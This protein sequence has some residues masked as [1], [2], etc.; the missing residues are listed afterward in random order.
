MLVSRDWLSD[1][2]RLDAP[3]EAL[4]ERLLMAGLNLEAIHA[5][6]NDTVIELEVTSNRPDCLGHVGVARELAVLLGLP[7]HLPD[8]RP[9]E[10]GPP[11]DVAVTIEDADICPC[12]TARVIR[13]VRVGPSPKW[14]IERLQAIGV[15]PVNNLVDVTNYVL[16]ECGQP[17]HAFDLARIR[18]RR[19]IVRRAR[20][21]ESFTALNHR[22]YHLTPAMGVIA[23]ADG[24]VALAGVMG[25]L[26]TEI[27]ADTV[28]VLLESAQFAPLVV[29]AAARGLALASPSSYRFERGPDPAA[30]DWA[31]RRACQ[32]IVE[33]AGGTLA[34]SPVAAG[35]LQAPQATVPLR[36][37]RV[38]EVL[39]MDVDDQRQRNILGGLGFVEA[40]AGGTDSRWLA[41]T[42]RRDCTREID[43]VEEIGRIEGYAHVPDEVPLSARRVEVGPRERIGRVA[44]DLLV[45][46]GFCEALTRS[47]VPIEAETTESPW[48]ARPALSIAPPL[49][50][51]AD[52]L[53]RS[54]LPSLLE[55]RSGNA[56]VGAGRADL[57][58]V[59][60]AY[61]PTAAETAVDGP[62]KEPFLVSLVTGGDFPLAKGIVE[63]LLTR[64]RIG[65]EAWSEGAERVEWRPVDLDLF[66][67][68]RAAEVVLHREGRQP[69]RIAVVGEIAVGQLAQR[70][71]EAPVA[72]AEVRLDCLEFAIGR[73]V[74]LRAA[75]DSPA[76]HRDINL[77]LD[78]AV[79]WGAVAAVIGE[80]GGPLLERFHLVQV[81][82]DAERLGTGRKSLVVALALRPRSG[83]L[84][85]EEANT[86]VAGIVTACAGRLGAELRR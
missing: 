69:E 53:R 11:A 47:V 13:G 28:D 32:L 10:S 72:A 61:L 25:G 81:W 49:V 66:T 21:G 65:V 4:A 26:G 22:D 8:P 85:G 18:G 56:A 33:M 51:G 7:L 52:R 36:G 41:P 20:E 79:P 31:S 5:A 73:D 3:T 39:G 68:G 48:T 86:V 71:L 34:A 37:G 30:V 82:E 27:G 15:E 24:P 67:G 77:V 83:S 45:G 16:F 14:L 1:Y 80:S 19:I 54:L 60:R 35:R 50:R 74:V 55:A 12:Y 6:G 46:L 78:R 38:A 29:R 23:D 58:E 84:S 40:P 70:S 59:A 57:F 43:L 9:L 44:T 63:A 76:V 2:L 62:L 75:S 42:W 17:L 64:L